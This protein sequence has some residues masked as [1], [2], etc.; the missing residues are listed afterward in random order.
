MGCPHTLQEYCFLGAFAGEGGVSMDGTTSTG[1]AD[2]DV[3]V[4]AALAASNA[5]FLWRHHC[6]V[7]LVVMVDIVATPAPSTLTGVG[8]LRRRAQPCFA[9]GVL[10]LRYFH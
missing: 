10:G 2:W 3:A 4:W 9:N 8:G 7:L 5:R 6:I 1:A